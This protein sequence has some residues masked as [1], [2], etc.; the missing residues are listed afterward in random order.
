MLEFGDIFADGL[1]TTA[2]LAISL[3]MASI[4]TAAVLWIARV[5]HVESD[6]GLTSRSVPA[7]NA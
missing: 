2:F 1:A 5:P 6:P 7:S 4:A 3:V